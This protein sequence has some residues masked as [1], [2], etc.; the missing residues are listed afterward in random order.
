MQAGSRMVRGESRPVAFRVNAPRNGSG[1][2][3]R[4]LAR[5]LES[6]KADGGPDR[7]AGTIFLLDRPFH[8][9]RLKKSNFVVFPVAKSTRVGMLDNLPGPGGAGLEA[10]P[11]DSPRD[12]RL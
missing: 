1:G 4:I 10:S 11:N 12:R 2:G 9:L 8:V 7:A 3:R 6:D 5:R